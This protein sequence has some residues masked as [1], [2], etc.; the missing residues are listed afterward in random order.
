MKAKRD[1]Q[2]PEPIFGIYDPT[3]SEQI[4]MM[5]EHIIT[6]VQ[7]LLRASGLAPDGGL[8]QNE[9]LAAGCLLEWAQHCLDWHGLDGNKAANTRVAELKA[10]RRDSRSPRKAA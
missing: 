10:E 4:T 1:L 3:D 8:E 9:L 5:A 7:A 6:T 2:R